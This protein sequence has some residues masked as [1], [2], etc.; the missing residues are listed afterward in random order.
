MHRSIKSE[1]SYAASV[2]ADGDRTTSTNGSAV[3]LAGYGSAL[4]ILAPG[5]ITDGTHTP[6]LQESA[7]GS[8][9]WGD[10]AAA[11][12]DGSFAALATGTMQRVGYKGT[13]GYL[14]VV[15]TVT[16][17][18]ATGGKYHAGILLAHPTYAP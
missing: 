8:T 13:K 1:T 3:A 15:I 14:R 7:N 10:V 6:K 18:P 17:S 2:A 5:T 16:G 9:G 12:L 11:D 4:V